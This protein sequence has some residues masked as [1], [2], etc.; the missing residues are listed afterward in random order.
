MQPDA[1]SVLGPRIGFE[2]DHLKPFMA[3]EEIELVKDAIGRSTFRADSRWLANISGLPVDRVNIALQRLL[4]RREL[5]MWSASCWSI[6]PAEP[7]E[8]L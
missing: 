7:A 2:P 5:R 1:I 4:R 8:P 3:R 6:E